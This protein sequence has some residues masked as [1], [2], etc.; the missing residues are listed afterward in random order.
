MMSKCGRYFERA[1]RIEQMTE[2][3]FSPTGR[4]AREQAGGHP[5]RQ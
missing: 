5:G 1:V 2:N 3:F 4:G